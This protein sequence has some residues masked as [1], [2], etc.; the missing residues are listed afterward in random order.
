MK[1]TLLLLGGGG[2]IGSHLIERLLKNSLYT[3]LAV[4]IDFSKLDNVK[5]N[6]STPSALHCI[7]LDVLDD[8]NASFLQMLI[9]NRADIVIDLVAIANPAV[10]MTNPLDVV[11]L[12][13]DA[14]LRIV[15]WCAA[16]EKRLIQF[17][18]CEVYGKSLHAVD[19]QAFAESDERIPFREDDSFIIRGPINR[20]RWIYACAKELL[21]RMVHAYGL[22]Q[23]LNYTIIR[24]FN[25]IGPRIDYLPS[26]RIHQTSGADGVPR[27]FSLFMDSLLFGTKPMQLVDGGTARRCYTH[28]SEAVEC[29]ALIIENKNNLCDRQIYNVGSPDNETT[30]REMAERMRDIF[31]AEFRVASDPPFRGIESVSAEQFY[32]KGYDDCDRRVPVID[33][34]VLHLDWRP[35]MSLD[36]VLRDLM[37]Y[38][39]ERH[40]SATQTHK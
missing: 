7:Y 18:T 36:A 32:G 31:D 5:K 19:A 34:A 39:V 3:I 24:P 4:D 12:N 9:K 1:K 22:E 25:F 20:H 27:V 10:C 14:N 35:E 23:N 17:S 29:I 30:I 33:K 37:R 21:E 15:G 2:F 16:Y 8:D 11:D 28:I 26:E 6:A 40:R 38:Y 13:Y